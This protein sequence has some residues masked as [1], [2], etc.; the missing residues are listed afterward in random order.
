M[1]VYTSTGMTI[2]TKYEVHVRVRKYVIMC[3][4]MHVPRFL[5]LEARIPKVPKIA[6][7]QYVYNISKK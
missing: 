5:I 2:I 6:S 4:K 3:T 1:L 7:L